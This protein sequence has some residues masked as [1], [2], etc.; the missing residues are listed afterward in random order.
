MPLAHGRE[1]APVQV[2]HVAP[3][4]VTMRRRPEAP[5]SGLPPL[6]GAWVT[7]MILLTM[8]IDPEQDI[9]DAGAY[10]ARHERR[11]GIAEP[12]PLLGIGAA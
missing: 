2:Q 4:S 8:T 5:S 9:A 3:Q 1:R 7:R 12:R 10:R 11:H 6:V